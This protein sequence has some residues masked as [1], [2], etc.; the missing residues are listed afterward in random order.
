MQISQMKRTELNIKVQRKRFVVCFFN[1]RLSCS[2]QAMSDN[3]EN[4]NV[5]FL[6]VDV[7]DAQVSLFVFFFCSKV[8]EVNTVSS[9]DFFFT[10]N[11]LHSYILHGNLMLMSSPEV[12]LITPR[13]TNLMSRK[14]RPPCIT[15]FQQTH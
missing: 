8:I 11:T 13:Q 12:Y 9:A 10:L 2:S 4:K 6:K 5:V 3:P 7:D 15:N 1:H 14:T